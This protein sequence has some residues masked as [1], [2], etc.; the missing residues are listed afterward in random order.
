MRRRIVLP[1]GATLADSDHVIGH[2]LVHAFQY[3]MLDR[4]IGM[5]PLWFVEG[6]AEYLSVGPRDVQTAMWLRDA[7]IEDR[8]PLIKNLDDPRYFPY[9]FGHAF[10]AYVAGRWGDKTI[11]SIM[12]A[13]SPT[14]GIPIPDNTDP[15]MASQV[16]AG[17]GASAVDMIELVTGKKQEQLS[18]EWHAAIR[19]TYGVSANPTR[20]QREVAGVM[21]DSRRE[22]GAVNVGP[23][24][25]PDG[26]KIAFLSARSR[27]SIDLY[28][29]DART[30]ETK[31][32]LID[33]AA[34]PHFESLQFLQSAGT[35]A[36]DNRRLAVATIRGGH[37]VIAIFD[38]DRGGIQEE[39]KYEEAGEIFQPAWSPDG[40]SLAFSA[41]VGG[42]TDLFVYDFGSKQFRRL[43]NDVSSDLQPAW[44]PGRIAPG[45]RHGPVLIES[46]D[47]D[48]HRLPCRHD[49]GVGRS[50]D[51]GLLEPDRQSL[52]SAVVARRTGAPG[53]RRSRR[54]AKRVADSHGRWRASAGHEPG[55]GR[56]RHHAR[57]SGDVGGRERG[58]A[59]DERVS[60]RGL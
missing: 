7:A 13:L 35:W 3:D 34:D 46:G 6:M 26:T 12:E 48:V 23:A 10:W 17:G 31:R 50:S 57:Q 59:C 5:L 58:H 27:L 49:C 42:V 20:N 54:R 25:S 28:V 38:G 45:V 55:H 2:E 53:D 44:S 30:G 9:R 4:N 32:K 39:I 21:V 14:G 24:L 47:A 19:E 60:R 1:M 8:L 37:P 43:T 33:T 22:R 15:A 40:Q 51:R 29:A 56:R 36:P 18:A 16:A 41:Q 11:A 52:Q